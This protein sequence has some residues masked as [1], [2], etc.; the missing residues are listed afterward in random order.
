M[1]GIY[2][3]IPFCASRCSYCDFFSTLRL[4]DAGGPYVDA[5]IAE[6]RLRRDELRG[7]SVKTL[8]LGGGT[9]SQLPMPLLERLLSGLKG[10]LDLDSPRPARFSCKDQAGLEA[11][12]GALMSGIDWSGGLI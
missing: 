2:V 9:P 11:F 5:L 7:E 8:Y 10:V 12:A 1:A 3:H 4:A 6:A